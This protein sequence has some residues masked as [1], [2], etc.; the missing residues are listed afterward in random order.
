MQNSLQCSGRGMDIFLSVAVPNGVGS[1]V[2]DTVCRN[3]R[4]M[5]GSL[6]KAIEQPEQGQCQEGEVQE[7]EVGKSEPC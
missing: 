1:T 6:N 3:C 2:G 7:E 4:E 5:T